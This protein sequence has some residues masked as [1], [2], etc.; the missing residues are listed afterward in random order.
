MQYFQA[1]LTCG[2][3]KQRHSRVTRVT[4][5]AFGSFNQHRAVLFFDGEYAVIERLRI[6]LDQIEIFRTVFQPFQHLAYQ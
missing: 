5:L 6:P 4:P 2:T 1:I 3:A